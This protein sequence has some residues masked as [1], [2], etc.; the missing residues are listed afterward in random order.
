MS[1][2]ML[3]VLARDV[4]SDGDD[5]DGDGAAAASSVGESIRVDAA[6]P[7]DPDTEAPG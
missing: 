3:P 5:G 7:C 6:V 2:S 1:I 4:G